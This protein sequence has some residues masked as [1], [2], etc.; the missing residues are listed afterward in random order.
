M[1]HVLK[2]K[3]GFATG[4]LGPVHVVAGTRSS[5]VRGGGSFPT[6]PRTSVPRRTSPSLFSNTAG[7]TKG[8]ECWASES[9]RVE[10]MYDRGPS[11]RTAK[12]HHVVVGG[13]WLFAV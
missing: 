5:H 7:C 1:C 9:S 2:A 3:S 10:S 8:R 11:E 6:R 13:G 4:C 12:E